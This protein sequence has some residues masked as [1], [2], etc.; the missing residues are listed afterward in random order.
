[1]KKS[2]NLYILFYTLALTVICAFLLAMASEG[3]KPYKEANI[4][5]EEKKSILGA[6][7]DISGRSKAEIEKLYENRVKKAYVVNVDGEV[8]DIPLEKV[9]VE[10][11]Y[12]KAS[13]DRLLPV[14]EVASEEDPSQTAYYVFPMY[15]FGLWD[16]IWGYV[17]LEADLNTIKG[18]IFAHKGETPGLGARIATKE[19]QKRYEGKQIFDGFTFNPVEMQKGEGNDYSDNPYKIDGMSGATITAVGLNRM[20]SDYFKSYLKFFENKRPQEVSLNN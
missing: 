4:K 9:K 16:T 18:T 6:T 5:L 17:A 1:M 19:V 3:L 11:E 14:Y 7:M 20:L 8:V 15:G 10:E 12:Q 2:S 13:N